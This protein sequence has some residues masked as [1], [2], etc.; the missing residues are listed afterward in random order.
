MATVNKYCNSAMDAA[1]TLIAQLNATSPNPLTGTLVITWNSG[2]PPNGGYFQAHY[3][4]TSGGAF[5]DIFSYALETGHYGPQPLN[6]VG[7]CNGLSR[8]YGYF[9]QASNSVTP[10]EVMTGL[11][12]AIVDM[13]ENVCGATVDSNGVQT[14][15]F[16]G[17]SE[18]GY[19]AASAMVGTAI[20]ACMVMIGNLDPNNQ[21][22]NA[23]A[24]QQ[25]TVPSYA[26]LGP[27]S[28]MMSAPSQD[29]QP[30]DID[31]AINNGANIYS[32]VSRT[33]TEP[34]P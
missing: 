21:P 33:F 24:V 19:I 13:L 29:N 9:R 26:V 18:P 3:Q 6:Y 17:R 1:G 22:V 25:P 16:S 34:G 28:I 23:P 20:D 4:L 10:L 32:V 8:S 7:R 5:S 15:T 14:V 31:V 11:W 2:G 30:L 27:Q 12:D